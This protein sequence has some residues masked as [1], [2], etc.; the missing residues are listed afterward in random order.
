[1]EETK[2]ASKQAIPRLGLISGLPFRS[3]ADGLPAGHR[4][5]RKDYRGIRQIRPALTRAFAVARVAVS[6]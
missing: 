1:L 6:A 2:L 3:S 5:K 4:I